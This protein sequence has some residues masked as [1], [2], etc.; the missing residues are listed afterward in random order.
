MVERETT[1]TI[2]VTYETFFFINN[3]EFITSNKLL[4]FYKYLLFKCLNIPC[5]GLS[6][7]FKST[8]SSLY[9]DSTFY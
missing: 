2:S 7:F 9:T 5:P 6:I 4:Q 1:L 3:D 8:S